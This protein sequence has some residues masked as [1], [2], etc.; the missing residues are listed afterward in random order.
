MQ[1]NYILGASTEGFHKMF[2]RTY[3]HNKENNV[4]IA[5]HGLT[6]NGSDFHY[7]GEAF[8]NS[9]FTVAPDV[10][11]R[12]RSDRFK[13]PIHYRYAQYFSD[14]TTL[15][16]RTGAQHVDWLGTSMGG[17]LGLMLAAQP[18]TPIRRLILNDVG[19]FIPNSAIERIKQY[20]TQELILQDWA[21]VEATLKFMYASFGIQTEEHWDFFIKNS[22][23]QRPDGT[24]TLHYDVR[25]ANT[26]PQEIQQTP[27]SQTDKEGNILF[28]DLWDKLTCP[29]LVIHGEQSDILT[30]SILAEMRKRGPQFDLYS[31]PTCG[32]APAL[33]AP[34]EMACIRQWLERTS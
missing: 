25:A 9:F 27:I 6:R 19:P 34:E 33:L 13:D 11:G 5:A 15:I 8:S 1:E 31:I 2:Y 32:H 18:N 22:V 14:L 28:W 23:R 21:Q 24:Y 17:L 20:A 3:G 4:L 10:V 7:I 16:A 30:P 26:Y 29:V 12:G